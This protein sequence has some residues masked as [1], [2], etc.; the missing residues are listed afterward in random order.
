MKKTGRPRGRWAVTTLAAALAI[1][2]MTAATAP[3]QA[4]PH[5]AVHA[6]TPDPSAGLARELLATTPV[7][8][9]A[10]RPSRALRPACPAH[11]GQMQCFALFRPQYAVNQTL[12]QGHPARPSGWSA[13]AL[14][15]AYRLPVSRHS[16][17]TIAV[18]IAYRTPKLAQYLKVY[19]EHYGLPECTLSSGCLRI[20]NQNGTT[21][22]V[23]PSG[24]H[25]GWDLEATLDVSM[26][27]VACPHCKILVVEAS[28]TFPQDLAKTDDTA[29]RLGATVI[30]NSYGQRENDSVMRYASHYK[31]PGQMIVAAS[32][33]S[34][35]DAANFPANLAGVTA[36]G[37]TALRRAHNARGFTEK[38]WDQ[39]G[40]YAASG[41][42]CSA[43]VT[44][45]GW[46]HDPHCAGRTVADVSAIAANVPI[47]EPSTAAGSPSAGP[48]PPP[49]SSPGSTAWPA[50]PGTSP[51][52]T[53]T[54]TAT[55]STT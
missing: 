53:S 1:G 5:A 11:P 55:T 3:A 39:P 8:P 41:S 36:V 33:D 26:I 15:R 31:H 21:K 32:G 23:P 45:P 35:F 29:A 54:P 40:F 42:G 52:A 4:A 18:S 9:A 25:L 47:F 10:A 49:R 37:G 43:Y 51:L 6:A 34:G 46:Q 20:V 24:A 28:K 44:K 50:T 30:T 19:R 38:V 27:S 17:Q 12:T 14:E 22:P 2:G 7:P 16:H 13:R 48:A